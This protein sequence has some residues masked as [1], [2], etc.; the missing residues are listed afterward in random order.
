MTCLEYH[1]N[2]SS[3]GVYPV[4]SGQHLIKVI[5]GRNSGEPTTGG[6]WPKLTNAH[7][8]WRLDLVVQSNRLVTVAQIEKVHTGSGRKVSEDTVHHSLLC[9]G[10]HSWRPFKAPV[11]TSVMNKA[12]SDESCFIPRRWPGAFIAYLGNTW[13]QEA[14]WKESK[15]AEVLRR[16]GT[17]F[18]ISIYLVALQ[19][20]WCN[21]E[22]KVWGLGGYSQWLELIRTAVKI[23]VTCLSLFFLP[24]YFVYVSKQLYNLLQKYRIF[25][26][27]VKKKTLPAFLAPTPDLATTQPPPLTA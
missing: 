13:H 19:A 20:A 14:L 27:Y 11:L 5:Q 26:V 3:C 18:P 4:C 8:Q 10:L 22:D 9:M 21:F 15:P 2:C 23:I 17:I 25:S 16:F 12:W 6:G 24:L 1:Q 7:G